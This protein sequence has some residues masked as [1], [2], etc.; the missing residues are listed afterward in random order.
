MITGFIRIDEFAKL[1]NKTVGTLYQY[2]SK[3]KLYDDFPA[4]GLQIGNVKFWRIKDAKA[5][6]KKRNRR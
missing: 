3:A 6:I 2:H 4:P 5:W 1:A